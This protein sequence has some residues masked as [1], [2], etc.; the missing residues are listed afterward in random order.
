MVDAL[1][2]RLMRRYFVRLTRAISITLDTTTHDYH[3]APAH[4]PDLVVFA[5]TVESNVEVALV[6]DLV[7]RATVELA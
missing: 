3:R 6:G 2:V 4:V 7:F 5:A 1:A